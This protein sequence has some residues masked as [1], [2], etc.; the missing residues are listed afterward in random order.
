MQIKQC[1]GESENAKAQRRHKT[2]QD[3][4]RIRS[5]QSPTQAE[6]ESME[7]GGV[8]FVARTRWSMTATGSQDNE[9][10]DR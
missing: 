9:T 3:Q 2:P 4:M 5:A 1:R 6:S 8:F 7:M 10:G